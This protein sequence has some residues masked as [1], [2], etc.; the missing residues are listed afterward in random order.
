M[1]I[2]SLD[3]GGT[4][5]W[6]QMD[7]PPHAMDTNEEDQWKQGEIKEPEHHGNLW[8]LLCTAQ[9]DILLCEGF[10]HQ[11][12]DFANVIALEYI[13]VV[14]LWMLTGRLV[15]VKVAFPP[16]GIYKQFWTKE[17]IKAVGLWKPNA[18]NATSATGHLLYYLTINMKDMT[19][20]NRLRS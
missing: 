13:G 12:R 14:K 11:Q 5:G 17:K 6:A 20:V 2:L 10:N 15:E 4:T 19:Y 7:R 1:R 16:P 8:E 9:P 3:P 18:R